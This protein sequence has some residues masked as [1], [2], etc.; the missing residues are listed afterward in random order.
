[1][2]Q[3]DDFLDAS[4]ELKSHIKELSVVY[5]FFEVL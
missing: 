5:I 4:A 2:K 3:P 1:M